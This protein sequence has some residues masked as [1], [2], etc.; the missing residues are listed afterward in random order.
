[1]MINGV[2]QVDIIRKDNPDLNWNVS[3]IPIP[4]NGE[5]ATELGGEN[6]CVTK[7]ADTEA[8]W[9]FITWLCGKE[10]S[11]K[12]CKDMSRFSARSDVDNEK[13][14]SDD[15]ITLFFANYMKDTHARV[16]PRWSECSSALQTAFQKVYSGEAKA[17][18]AMAEAA[19]EVE[20][21][22]EEE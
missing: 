11:P 10:I 5:N 8:C 14:F 22:N 21:I 6:L 17:A 16:H 15:E 2:W 7:G 1:M 13:W 19:K 9:E 18:D 20:K 3:Y 12:F 4:E